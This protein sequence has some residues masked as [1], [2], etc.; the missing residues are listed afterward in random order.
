MTINAK[1]VSDTHKWMFRVNQNC[2]ELIT[3]VYCSKILICMQLFHYT[4]LFIEWN[5]A[6]LNKYFEKQINT[7]PKQ[8]KE[9]NST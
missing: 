1:A 4:T 5:H 8:K 2:Y 3:F 7:K 6:Q 9:K